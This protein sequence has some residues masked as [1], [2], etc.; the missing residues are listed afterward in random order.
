MG[1]FELKVLYESG[2][3]LPNYFSLMDVVFTLKVSKYKKAQDNLIVKIVIN[4]T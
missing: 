1:I 4:I 3:P 2:N